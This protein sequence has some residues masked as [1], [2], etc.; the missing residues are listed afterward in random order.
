MADMT[1]AVP[2]FPLANLEQHVDAL[3]KTCHETGLFYLRLDDAGACERCAAAAREFFDSDEE[4]KAACSYEASPAFRGY[5][6]L[7]VENTAGVID[8]REQIEL[9]REDGTCDGVAQRLVGANRW[10]N[11]DGALQSACEPWLASMSA[12]A[13]RVTRALSLGLGLEASALDERVLGTTPHWQAKLA[14]YPPNVGPGV[15]AHSDSGWLTLLWADQPGLEAQLRTGEWV[16][17]PPLDGAVAVNLGEMLQLASGGY[18]RATPHRVGPSSQR[19]VS[20]PFFWNPSL[21]AIVDV[22]CDPSLLPWTRDRPEP[23][24]RHSLLRAYGANA[25]KSLARSH[26][27]VFERH[28]PDLYVKEDGTVAA[29]DV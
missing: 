2:I 29:R 7:G 24:K 28:H 22:V 15:G 25:F 18:Y 14:S 26:P 19:R 8:A 27:R 23:E 16:A 10:P 17:V 5:M 20:L 12:A 3:R 9:G 13:A 4:T 1:A 6:R 11:D 21:S